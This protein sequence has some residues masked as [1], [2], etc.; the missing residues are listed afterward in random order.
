MATCEYQEAKMEAKRP[1]SRSGGGGGDGAGSE[2]RRRTE[3]GLGGGGWDRRSLRRRRDK[4]RKG[5][6]VSPSFYQMSSN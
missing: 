5:S 1:E 3:A 2:P 4:S 6:D